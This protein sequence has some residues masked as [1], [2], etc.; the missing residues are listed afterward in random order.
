MNH[1]LDGC[2]RTAQWTPFQRVRSRTSSANGHLDDLVNGL[3]NKFPISPM[4]HP[5]SNVSAN[6][7]SNDTLGFGRLSECYMRPISNDT[8]GFFNDAS[9]SNITL[10]A[11]LNEHL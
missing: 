8:L 3:P 2:V 1:V 6:A 10:S 9:R 7:I 4:M 11:V 5:R